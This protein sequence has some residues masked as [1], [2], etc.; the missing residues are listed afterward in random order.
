MMAATIDT[1]RRFEAGMPKPLFQTG[2]ATS[3]RNVAVTKDGQ[4]FLVNTGQQRSSTVPL[5]VVVNWLAA[6]QK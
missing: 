1:T 4:R 3:R 6:V 2:A 5:T